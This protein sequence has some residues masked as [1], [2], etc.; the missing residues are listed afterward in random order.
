MGKTGIVVPILQSCFEVKIYL[1]HG[2]TSVA[3]AVINVAR[4]EKTFLLVPFICLLCANRNPNPPVP[5]DPEFPEHGW[6][7]GPGSYTGLAES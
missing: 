3:R 5:G 1:V 6:M 7:D 4:P 2:G